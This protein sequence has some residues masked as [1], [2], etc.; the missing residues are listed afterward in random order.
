M[1]AQGL[2]FC[3]IRFMVANKS[4]PNNGETEMS[5]IDYKGFTIPDT[6]E[7]RASVDTFLACK[8][9][10]LSRLIDRIIGN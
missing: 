5:A 3:I 2:N 10:I 4:G 8:P 1:L 9:S 7:A 6:N